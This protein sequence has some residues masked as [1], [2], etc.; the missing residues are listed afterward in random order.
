MQKKLILLAAVLIGAAVIGCDTGTNPSTSSITVTFDADGGTPAIQ[1]SEPDYASNKVELPQNPTKPDANFEAWY[2]EK[3]GKGDAYNGLGIPKSDITVYAH[4]VTI[5]FTDLP[6]DQQPF[7]VYFVRQQ[8][9]TYTE[10]FSCIFFCKIT[11]TVN[12][13]GILTFDDPDLAYHRPDGDSNPFGQ[14]YSMLFTLDGGQ[15]ILEYTD[16]LFDR[17]GTISYTND[18]VNE[19]IFGSDRDNETAE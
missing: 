13:N 6:P 3:D 11:A 7:T 19:F 2:T 9:T 15:T 8:P 4:W 10:A 1:T 5:T 14:I 18:Q 16:S 12:E 17:S